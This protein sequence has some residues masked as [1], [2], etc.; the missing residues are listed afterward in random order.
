MIVAVTSLSCTN[1]YNVAEISRYT[2]SKFNSREAQV[3]NAYLRRRLAQVEKF[4]DAIPP[5]GTVNS[6]RQSAKLAVTIIS[7]ATLGACDLLSSGA[8]GTAEAT[9]VAARGALGQAIEDLFVGNS[10]ALVMARQIQSK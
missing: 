2:R 5:Q 8:A 3:V 9:A 1:Q 10:Q 6:L 7:I 4:V